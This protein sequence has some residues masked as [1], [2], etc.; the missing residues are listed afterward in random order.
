M[1]VQVIRDGVK[2]AVV[3]VH[4]DQ[5][6]PGVFQYN[7]YAIV[8]HPDYR[9]ATQDN[10]LHPGEVGILWT[11]GLGPTDPPAKTGQG[12]PRYA[13]IA[14]PIS[15]FIDGKEAKVL[16]AGLAPDLVG[17]YQINFILPQEASSGEGIL[18]VADK[19]CSFKIPLAKE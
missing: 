12:A 10:P 16:F 8:T 9:L 18:T 1:R 14:N 19:Q 4:I 6:S 3:V 5:A 15:L 11:T 7:G 13:Q 2:S 17:V